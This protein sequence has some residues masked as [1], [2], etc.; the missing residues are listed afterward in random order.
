MIG[1]RKDPTRKELLV[2][3]RRLLEKPQNWIQGANARNS[4]GERVRYNDK[5]ACF[6]CLQG[7]FFR[8]FVNLGGHSG[9][10]PNCLRDSTGGEAYSCIAGAIGKRGVSGDK[11]NDSKDTTHADILGILDRAIDIEETWPWVQ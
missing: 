11:F 7:A 5:D 2:E 1:R 9:N 10:V 6:F 8:A 4:H 3:T